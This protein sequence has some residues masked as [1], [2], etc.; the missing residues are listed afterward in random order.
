MKIEYDKYQ[1]TRGHLVDAGIDLRAQEDAVIPAKGNY[2]FDTGVKADINAGFFGKL[3][4]KSGL[5][6]NHD[7]VCLG[8]TIDSGYTGTIKAKLY[9]MGD[10]DYQVHAGDKIVQM[11][12][13]P[14]MWADV[15]IEDRFDRGAAGFGST[16][17]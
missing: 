10:Q 17:K 14:C 4:S 7:I 12:I 16:G 8:G 2:I 3:E 9:N 1:P 5:N 11:I 6:V 15:P 13:I